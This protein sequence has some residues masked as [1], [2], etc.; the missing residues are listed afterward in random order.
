[1]FF[2]FGSLSNPFADQFDL[3]SGEASPRIGRRHLRLRIVGGNTTVQFT[4]IRL[5][6]DNTGIAIGIGEGAGF[7]VKPHFGL[8]LL[9]IR[10]MALKAVVGKNRPNIT[11]E[12]NLRNGVGVSQKYTGHQG[13]RE[14]GCCGD[15]CS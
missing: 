8:A 14:C 11:I 13:E 6:R 15:E 1:M 7:A 9:L 4:L 5:A 12:I 2:P 3:S 10:S